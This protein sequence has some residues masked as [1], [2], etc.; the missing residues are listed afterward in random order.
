M[1]SL[2]CSTWR[3]SRATCSAT[4]S[5]AGWIAGSCCCRSPGAALWWYGER[6]NVHGGGLGMVLWA[7]PLRLVIVYHVTWLVNS[8]THAF[9]YRNF[10]SPDLSRNCWWVAIL[11]FGEGWHNNHHAHP[12]S[13]RHGLRWFEFDIT[14]QH[15]KLLRSWAWPSESVRPATCPVRPTPQLLTDG[16]PQFAAGRTGHRAVSQLSSLASQHGQE[17]SRAQFLVAGSTQARQGAFQVQQLAFQLCG[18]KIPLTGHHRREALAPLRLLRRVRPQDGLAAQAPGP[19]GGE[20]L[21][22]GEAEGRGLGRGDA[23]VESGRRL[24]LAHE[25]LQKSPGPRGRPSSSLSSGTLPVPS[26]SSSSGW[27]VRALR[28]SALPDAAIHWLMRPKAR[29]TSGPGEASLRLRS[30]DTWEL[31]RRPRS[32]TSAKPGRTR[33]DQPLR[34]CQALIRCAKASRPDPISS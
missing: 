33:W 19:A 34:S 25:N 14:W 2:P 23:Q 17:L 9:G 31:W 5:T 6:A 4:P 26:A 7:I 3:G 12:A 15:I 28:L 1:R 24:T 18:F 13:A 11:S 8:A 20:Q 22:Q 29:N 30:I 10:D 32:S 27:P 16:G 21:R